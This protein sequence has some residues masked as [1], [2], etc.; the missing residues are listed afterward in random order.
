MRFARPACP[1]CS[2]GCNWKVKV[3][4]REDFNARGRRGAQLAD[5]FFGGAGGRGARKS[6]PLRSAADRYRLSRGWGGGSTHQS[7][8]F[9][10]CESLPCCVDILVETPTHPES[11]WPNI[12]PTE[13]SV[14]VKAAL[15]RFNPSPLKCNNQREEFW[16]FIICQQFEDA[17]RSCWLSMSLLADLKKLKWMWY[18]DWSLK[19]FFLTSFC[20][21]VYS[22][23][24]HSEC[25][26][27]I[28]QPVRTGLGGSDKGKQRELSHLLL[29][30]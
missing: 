21:E 1:N 28:L 16:P 26:V 14:F 18:M 2:S 17:I 9:S 19:S 4:R 13:V 27:S 29:W 23:L 15:L 5:R 6:T 10:S 20:H 3:S 8:T 25:Y 7:Y 12:P 22:L 24:P 11:T 30:K